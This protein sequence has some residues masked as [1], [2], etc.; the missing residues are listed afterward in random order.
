MS[1]PQ[2]LL[3]QLFRRTL[4]MPASAARCRDSQ[5]RTLNLQKAKLPQRR[6]M[7]NRC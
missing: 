6:R 1:G 5:Q 3:A 4:T 2:V 7:H